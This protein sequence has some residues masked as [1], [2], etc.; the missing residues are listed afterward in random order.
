[1]LLLL[2]LLLL[3]HHVLIHLPGLTPDKTA[4]T[5]VELAE[6]GGLSFQVKQGALPGYQPFSGVTAIQLTMKSNSNFKS[7]EKTATPKNE[8]RQPLLQQQ[9]Q[10]QQ[11]DRRQGR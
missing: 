8:V 11:Q 5:C 4:A 6:N 1:V 2:L 3:L 9:Q 10:Q 7:P